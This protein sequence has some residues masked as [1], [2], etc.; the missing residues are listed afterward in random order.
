MIAGNS[1]VSSVFRA[2]IGAPMV[3][4]LLA[5][6]IPGERSWNYRENN[7]LVVS[8]ETVSLVVTM[9]PGQYE[10]SNE[11]SVRLNRFLRDY[12]QRG[13]GA[14]RINVAPVP[15]EARLTQERNDEIRQLLRR[16]GMR[17]SEFSIVVGETTDM[18]GVFL[19]YG[20]HRVSVPSC[21]NIAW[22][23]TF[24]GS[25][26]P[27]NSFGCAYQK[28]LG[29]IIANPGDLLEARDPSAKP[30]ARDVDVVRKY[31]AGAPTGVTKAAEQS[32]IGFGNT[33]SGSAQ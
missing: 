17:Q 10:L 32:N 25:N 14:L 9:P 16:A 2:C 31:R 24:D 1:F 6:C 26:Y 8:K 7:P 23:P 19:A 30:T 29:S 13:R 27:I 4:I 21:T 12:I 5:G 20:A 18:D 15:G 22:G 3:A 33:V 11:D 28:A